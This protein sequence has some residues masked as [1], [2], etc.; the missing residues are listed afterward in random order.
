MNATL[1]AFY[2]RFVANSQRQDD[3]EAIQRHVIFGI[4]NR[5]VLLK[6]DLVYLKRICFAPFKEYPVARSWIPPAR[7][8]IQISSSV[9]RRA[10]SWTSSAIKMWYSTSTDGQHWQGARS[11]G[12]EPT[13]EGDLQRNKRLGCYEIS[14]VSDTLAYSPPRE[15]DSLET[16][17]WLFYPQIA[18]AVS[19]GW[20]CLDL[21]TNGELQRFDELHR[22]RPK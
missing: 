16:S 20:V 5:E 14:F 15:S 18:C 10:I 17:I 9:N 2:L 4:S 7:V 21:A 13:G 1:F 6:T 11:G 19:N 8:I 22:L 12:H 3:W